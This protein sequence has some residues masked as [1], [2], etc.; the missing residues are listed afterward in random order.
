V[1]RSLLTP[2]ETLWLDGYHARVAETL[3]PLV[4]D[5]T[6]GWLADATRPIG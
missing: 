3:A 1:D 2:E 5:S 4:D 6:R